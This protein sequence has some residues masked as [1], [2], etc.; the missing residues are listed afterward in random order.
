M[1]L[2]LM[3]SLTYE[4][5]IL[6]GEIWWWSVLGL[7][8]ALSLA[9]QSVTLYLHVVFLVDSHILNYRTNLII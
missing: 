1:S 9:L 7:K 2:T 3:T 4:A 5:L 6:Q 8:V